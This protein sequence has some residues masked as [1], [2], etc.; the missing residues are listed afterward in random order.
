MNI[1]VR[2]AAASDR[3][4]ILA[5]YLDAFGE[6]EGRRVAALALD[7]LDAQAGTGIFALAAEHDTTLVGH[8]AFSPVA[9][10]A[11]GDWRGALLAPLAVGRLLQQRGIGSALVE[12]GV[13]RL[14]E[15]G[16]DVV[17]VYG[18]PAY[19]GRF[20]FDAVSA[21]PFQP[22]YPLTYPFGWQARPLSTGRLPDSPVM[23]S[24]VPAL[25]DPGLW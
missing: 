5:L 8:I 20:G 25:R 4:A 13:A 16:I 14:V 7:L 6:D 3:D 1:Q 17:F 23:L 12:Q 11:G 9:A 10:S 15:M 19:Y 22:P 2:D 21:T 24:C 18:D